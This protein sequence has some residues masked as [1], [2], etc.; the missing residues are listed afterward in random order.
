MTSKP[1]Q[2]Q[3]PFRCRLTDN[4]YWVHTRAVTTRGPLSAAPVISSVV[5]VTKHQRS[6]MPWAMG[7]SDQAPSFFNRSHAIQGFQLLAFVFWFFAFAFRVLDLM[8]FQNL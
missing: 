8:R 5:K 4:F 6:R 1:L 2:K 3:H 7:S